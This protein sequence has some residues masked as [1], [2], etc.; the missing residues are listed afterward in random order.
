LPYG[1]V[2]EVGKDGLIPLQEGEDLL[3]GEEDVRELLD[4]A[5]NAD[6][7]TNKSSTTTNGTT[8]AEL[9]TTSS[10]PTH[11]ITPN[12]NRDIHDTNTSQTLTQKDVTHLQ[13]SSSGAQMVAALISNSSTFSSKTAFSQAKYVKRKQMKYMLRCRIVRITPESLCSAMH[14]KDSRKIS[15]LRSD[16][17]GC[18]LT[19]ANVCAGQRVLVMDNAVQGIIS[20]TVTRRMG[21]YGTVFALYEGQQPSYLEVVQRMNFTARERQS[22]KWVGMGE[23]FASPSQKEEQTE[24]LKDSNGHVVDVEKRDRE[25]I[26]WPCPLMAHTRNYLKTEV[27]EE[28]KIKEFLDKR[29]SRFTRK[30]TRLSVLEL[31]DLVDSCRDREEEGG[32]SDSVADDHPAAKT[33]GD[34]GDSAEDTALNDSVTNSIPQSIDPKDDGLEIRQCDSLIIATKYNP[35]TVI[36]R[37]LPYLA[38]SCPFVIFHE[39]KEPLLE[40]F[41]TLQ[42]GGQVDNDNDSSMPMMCRRNI[43][44]NLRLTDT[45]F[46]EYQVLEGRTHPNMTM[47][48]NGGYLLTGTKL[49]PRTGT[50]EMDSETVRMLRAKMGP[51]RRPRKGGARE[52]EGGGKRKSDSD[53]AVEKE[54]KKVKT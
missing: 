11:H 3:P 15:N 43:A 35:T 14:T 34:N 8:Q 54:V 23:V 29:C 46:R 5:E 27:V 47:S 44:I 9:N 28:K 30:L 20:A 7:G 48:Q 6:D 24:S 18:I 19:G 16:T 45:W 53:A 25:G 17:L 38:P 33:N 4:A 13:S 49:C 10:N 26:H 12:D 42:N 39:F 40:T 36:L 51:S 31:R 37:L 41:R 2:L 52:A 22:L 1:T 32:A 50:N 21:G